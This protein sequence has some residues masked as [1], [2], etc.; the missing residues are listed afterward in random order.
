MINGLPQK[1]PFEHL[2]Y[3]LLTRTSQIQ[4]VEVFYYAKL[5]IALGKK[6]SRS[7]VYSY[8]PI[9]IIRTWK[10]KKEPW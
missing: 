8:L 10:R 3:A 2:N 9:I 4:L 7:A 5:Q 6:K 1:V